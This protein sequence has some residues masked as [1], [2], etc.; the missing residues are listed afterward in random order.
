M[1]FSDMRPG[2]VFVDA[3]KPDKR[4]VVVLKVYYAHQSMWLVTLGSQRGPYQVYTA[5]SFYWG[6]LTPHHKHRRSGY[7]LDDTLPGNTREA[8]EAVPRG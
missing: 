2:M 4:R 1:R 3:A 6:P 8:W 7:Y 5:A